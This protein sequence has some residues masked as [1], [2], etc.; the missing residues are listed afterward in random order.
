M[1]FIRTTAINKIRAIS[2][3]KKVIQGGTSAGKTFGILPVLID[4]ATKTDRLEISV[5]SESI[6]HLR[7]GAMKDFI[8]IMMETGRYIDSGWNRSL[9]TYNFVNGSYIE[10]FSADQEGRLRGARRNILY[11]NEANNVPFDAYH[12]LAIRT[13]N[14]IYL[15]FNPTAQFWAHTEVLQEPDSELLILTY[16]DNEA[17]P[18]NVLQD[19]NNA[20]VK[21]ETSDYWK[22]WVRVYVNGEIGS[23]QGVIFSNWNQ[24]DKMPETWKWKAYGIDWGFTNDPTAVVEVCEF[25]GKLWINEILYEKGLTNADIADK[26]DGFRGQE[27]IADSAEPKS[28]EDIRRRGFRIR[29]CDKGRDSVRSGIDKLQQYQLMITSGSTNIIKEVRGYSWATDRT[30]KE[31]GE[32]IDN[33]NHAWDAI[34]Y[35]AMEKLKARSGQY[36]IR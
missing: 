32:P 29:P 13:S 22:N 34:R 9:L 18:A 14:E 8:K 23:L 3:R 15:D 27:F 17:L 33:M 4:L 21:A 35:T 24:C 26:L 28:I 5:V 10:F 31:T 36:S 6:P 11:V 7:R 16:K 30:G 2:A 25:D 20:I 19:F 1:T 12:Q